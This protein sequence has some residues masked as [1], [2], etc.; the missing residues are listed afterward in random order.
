MFSRAEKG[1]PLTYAEMDLNFAEAAASGGPKVTTITYDDALPTV[2]AEGEILIIDSKEP[3]IDT[4]NT[5]LTETYTM[6]DSYE[7][8]TFSIAMNSDPQL[9]TWQ[10]TDYT[11][12]T[13]KLLEISGNDAYILF[14]PNIDL[15]STININDVDVDLSSFVSIGELSPGIGLSY[16]ASPAPS[17]LTSLTSTSTFIIKHTSTKTNTQYFPRKKYS[18]FDNQWVIVNHNFTLDSADE[19][20]GSDGDVLIMPA[21]PDDVSTINKTFASVNVIKSGDLFGYDP[22]AVMGYTND[23]VDIHDDIFNVIIAQKM[24]GDFPGVLIL[25]TKNDVYNGFSINGI[26]INS[27]STAKDYRGNG[28]KMCYIAPS[29]LM[30]DAGYA[31]SD[32]SD[33]EIDAL[34]QTFVSSTAD[35]LIEIT[36]VIKHP[37]RT[38]VKKGKWVNTDINID[39]I[40]ITDNLAAHD[41]DGTMYYTVK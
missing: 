38:F 34:F 36:N 30:L 10:S 35:I 40:E 25:Q 31:V 4:V 1:A 16:K 20:I 26:P 33:T 5:T 17:E 15:P 41:P 8:P 9:G 24:G 37:K 2:A 3:L 39:T 29:Q 12:P 14:G 18:R 28:Q 21:R 19:N 23:G 6:V 7:D 11:E 27:D 13:L 32:M 22:T